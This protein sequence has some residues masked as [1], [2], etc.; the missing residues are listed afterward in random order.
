MH[1]ASDICI[2]PRDAY[3]LGMHTASGCILPRDAYCLGMHT[4]SGCIL[5]RD[6]FSRKSKSNVRFFEACRLQKFARPILEDFISGMAWHAMACHAMQQ[7]SVCI[8][9][10]ECIQPGIY[11]RNSVPD[12]SQSQLA[13]RHL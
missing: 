2:L 12:Y 9:A 7:E 6:A 4:A 3:C 10:A 11:N 5:P 1:T 13:D 8:K